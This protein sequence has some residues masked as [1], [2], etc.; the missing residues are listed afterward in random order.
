[1]GT[2]CLSKFQHSEQSYIS[3]SYIIL[4]EKCQYCMSLHGFRVYLWFVDRTICVILILFKLNCTMKICFESIFQT[5]NLTVLL[6]AGHLLV[7][8]RW[9]CPR[10]CYAPAVVHNASTSIVFNFSSPRTS[11]WPATVSSAS[12]SLSE[13]WSLL[14]SRQILIASVHFGHLVLIFN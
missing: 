2:R 11:P 4:Y 7:T 10:P 9:R 1:M 12:T 5:Q 6:Q 3:F 13:E 8:P 14:N